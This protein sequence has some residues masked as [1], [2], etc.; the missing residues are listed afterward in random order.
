MFQK[1]QIILKKPQKFY[2]KTQVG[3]IVGPCGKVY[4]RQAWT[5]LYLPDY[6]PVFLLRTKSFAFS[7]LLYIA[8]EW[9]FLKK[10]VQNH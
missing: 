10:R 6:V 9:N 4:K 7:M 1:T 3:G 2:E 8:I 5:L